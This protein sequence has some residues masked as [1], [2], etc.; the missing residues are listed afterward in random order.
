MTRLE[1]LNEQR[2]EL[3]FAALM[4]EVAASEGRKAREENRRLQ[5]DPSAAVPE[6]VLKR[7]RKVIRREFNARNARVAAKTA[8][9]LFNKVAVIVAIISLLCAAAFALS[10]KFRADSMNLLMEVFEDKTYLHFTS[11]TAD[12]SGGTQ[13]L[14]PN[15]V[16][17]GYELEL[18]DTTEPTIRY[19]YLNGVGQFI[20]I[21]KFE[22][23]KLT[24]SVDTDDTNLQYIN[25]QGV[26]AVLTE[27]DNIIMVSWA[28]E[29][30]LAMITVKSNGLSQDELLKIAENLSY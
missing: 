25:M 5:N 2:E 1:E 21:T 8:A 23:E 27:D 10:P 12:T 6:P 20:E 28:D 26:T 18:E 11:S 29:E 3:L 13:L 15:W 17:E 22:S 16:P 7:C 30:S 24:L 4:E 9:R 19:K 14:T